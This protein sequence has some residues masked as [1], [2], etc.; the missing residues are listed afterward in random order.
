MAFDKWTQ[1]YHLTPSGWFKGTRTYFDK[2]QGKAVPRP[3]DAVETWEEQGYQSSGWARDE[4][5]HHCTWHDSSQSASVREELRSRF[6][7]PFHR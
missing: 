5:S 7:S 6:S 1:E 4:Y 3:T 2:V